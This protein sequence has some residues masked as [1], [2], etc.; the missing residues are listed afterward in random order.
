MD[1]DMVVRGRADRTR[2]SYLAAVE[3]LARFYGRSPDGLSQDEVQG[4]VLHLIKERKVSPSTCNVAVSAFRFLYLTTLGRDRAE[5]DIPHSKR[6]QRLPE[7]FSREE[8]ARLLEA[9]SN[10]RDHA[11]LATAYAA[12]LRV[13]ELVKLKPAD[14]DSTRMTIRVEQAKGAKDRYSLLSPLLL[15]ELRS[16]W[17]R[18]RPRVWLFETRTGKHLDVSAVQ[19]IYMAAKRRARIAKRGGIHALRHAFATHLLEAGE[20]LHTIQRLLGHG[21]LRTTS[22]YLH[23]TEAGLKSKAISRDLLELPPARLA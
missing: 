7:I 21:D 5:F 11:L 9:A 1:N 3:G 14:I 16:Y 12:G 4:Y 18:F 8:I 17:K 19:K 2:E 22:R 15:E 13:G 10:P 23:L 6:P 20:D